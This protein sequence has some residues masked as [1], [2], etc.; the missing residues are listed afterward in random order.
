MPFIIIIY[1][2]SKNSI[3]KYILNKLLYSFKPNNNFNIL[4]DLEPINFEKLRK[5]KYNKA[6]KAITFANIIVKANYNIKYKV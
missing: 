6:N 1:N 5:I 3:I 2:N 4:T